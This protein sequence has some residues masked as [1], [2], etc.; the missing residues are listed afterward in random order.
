MALA[1]SSE[2]DVRLKVRLAPN[3]SL[4]TVHIV[5]WR[6]AIAGRAAPSPV[7]TRKPQPCP[8]DPGVTY[9]NSDPAPGQCQTKMPHPPCPP[10][11][12]LLNGS[13]SGSGGNSVSGDEAETAWLA[14][15]TI[16]VSNAIL[17]QPPPASGLG[18]SPGGGCRT[19]E[20][21]LHQLGS[22]P[23][24]I[25]KGEC[26]GKVTMLTIASPRPWAL[27]EVR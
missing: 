5:D 1:S 27:L 23:P 11:P 21:T 3:R 13:S 17:Q 19:L 2:R 18:S 8:S 25:V 9:C 26:L 24:Q 12:P 7:C 14:P 20:F 22:A 6:A 4:A 15:F 10:C 16:N